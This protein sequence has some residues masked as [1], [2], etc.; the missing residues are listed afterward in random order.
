MNRTNL[1]NLILHY[2]ES[3]VTDM[4]GGCV[5]KLKLFNLNENNPLSSIH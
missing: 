5:G 3:S 4:W 1:F 2:P